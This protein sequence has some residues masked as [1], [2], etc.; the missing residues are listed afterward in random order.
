MSPIQKILFGCP[1]TGKSYKV[2]E[3]AKDQLGISEE[4]LRLNIVKAVFYPEYKYSDFMGKLLPLSS[5]SSINYKYYPGHFLQALSKAYHSIIHNKNQN[6]LLVID[7]LNR[8][9]AAAIFGSIFQLLDRNYNGWSS[10]CIDISEMEMFGLLSSMGYKI[11]IFDDNILV[12]DLPFDIFIEN[13]KSKKTGNE[14]S[15]DKFEIFTIIQN[16]QIRIPPNL[17]IIATVNTSDESIY[18]LDTAFKRRWDWE[19]IKAPCTSD[20]ENY[21]IDKQIITIPEKVLNTIIPIKKGNNLLVLKLYRLIVGINEFI[22]S[23]HKSIRNIEDK[24][25]GWWFINLQSETLSLDQI[26][27]KLMFYLWD[28]VFARDKK[29]LI[30]LIEENFSDNHANLITYAD[31]LIY[32]D[33][34]LKYWHNSVPMIKNSQQD[35]MPMKEVSDPNHESS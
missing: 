11:K 27:D 24:Q 35:D 32:T 29:P 21:S 8:G 6:H 16:Y 10:Y 2:I 14:Y 20:I 30:K 12:E 31:F 5:V 28:S 17:S 9:N 33:K 18:Y 15:D 3:I 7:E 26:K 34:L 22:K 1:G 4:E 13:E 25:I 23:N 19:Y